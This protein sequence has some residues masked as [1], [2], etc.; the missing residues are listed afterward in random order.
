M[1]AGPLLL[2]IL[3]AVIVFIIVATAFLKIHPFLV[4]MAAAYLTGLLVGMPLDELTAAVN[5]GIGNLMR[6]IGLVIVT[7]T[8]IGVILE[9]SG[10]ALRMAEIVVRLVGAKR[11]Q[12]AMSLIGAIVS[13]PVFCDSGYV[14]LTSLNR[15][16]AK[17]A[18]VPLASMSIAL[19]TGLYATHTLV[20]PTPGPI[21]A[22]GY[23][24]ASDYLGMVILV[25][26]LVSVPTTL[27]GYL[28]ATRV[29]IHIKI[30][31]K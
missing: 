15:A 24:G 4:L 14:I 29:A 19:A 9:K 26:L 31:H 11:P 17:K 16:T 21:A 10:A 23:L 28:W 6:H 1:I 7:G 18:G 5:T 27:V 2:V 3:L 13:V 20:P 25:G 22:A 12:L 8:I 30:A